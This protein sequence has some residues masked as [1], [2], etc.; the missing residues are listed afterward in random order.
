MNQC[1]DENEANLV[2][3]FGSKAM[4]EIDN[5]YFSLKSKFLA[6]QNEGENCQLH[7]QTMTIT[8]F[9]EN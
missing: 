7:N 8:S 2:L 6:V 9:Y 1:I 3:C 5:I 4:F